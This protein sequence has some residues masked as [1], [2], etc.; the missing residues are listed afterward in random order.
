MP[1]PNPNDLLTGQEAEEP[2]AL[3][4]VVGIRPLRLCAAKLPPEAEPTR[5]QQV[6]YSAQYPRHSYV[7]DVEQAVH[8]GDSI[9]GAIG[10]IKVE[11]THGARVQSSLPTSLHHRR[12]EMRADDV[13]SALLEELAMHSST[14]PDLQQLLVGLPLEQGRELL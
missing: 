12:R 9:E 7:G 3:A 5:L 8:G 4:V 13:Q 1:G 6:S 14:C 10:E 2:F 11:G